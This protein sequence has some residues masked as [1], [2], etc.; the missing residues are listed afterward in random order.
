MLF[1]LAYALCSSLYPNS[2]YLIP[3]I[4]HLIITLLTPSCP[5]MID[6]LWS[7]HYDDGSYHTYLAH[8]VT[9]C[10]LEH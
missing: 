2:L 5:R 1:A 3:P 4:S 8:V 10:P 7:D 9:L 6:S